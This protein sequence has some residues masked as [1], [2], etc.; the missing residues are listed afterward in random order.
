MTDKPAPKLPLLGV[1]ARRLPGYLDLTAL[2]E[3][4]LRRGVAIVAMLAVWHDGHGFR[5]PVPGVREEALAVELQ[6]R[7]IDRQVYSWPAWRKAEACAVRPDATFWAR[8]QRVA[9]GCCWAAPARPGPAGRHD[10]RPAPAT[11]ACTRPC[12]GSAPAGAGSGV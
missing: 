2:A 1:W 6:R 5:D 7:G 9:P 4:L 12:S 10:G 11:P 8:Q 3:E